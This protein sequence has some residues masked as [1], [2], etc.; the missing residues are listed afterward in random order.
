MVYFVLCMRLSWSIC[1]IEIQRT[2]RLLQVTSIY[3]NVFVYGSLNT[4]LLYFHDQSEH[5]LSLKVGS[6]RTQKWIQST[7]VSCM[8]CVSWIKLYWSSLEAL[9]PCGNTYNVSNLLSFFLRWIMYLSQF[10]SG[11]CYRGYWDKRIQHINMAQLPIWKHV[12]MKI[13]HVERTEKTF[14]IIFTKNH[15]CVCDVMYYVNSVLDFLSSSSY[16]DVH[17]ACCLWMH[18]WTRM[19]DI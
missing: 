10:I 8:F 11:C 4:A 5:D 7:C 17:V 19:R 15:S 16:R 18:M 1:A 14:N 9:T 3:T 13:T 6:L 2:L 12:F